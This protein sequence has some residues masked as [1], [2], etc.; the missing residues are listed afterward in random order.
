MLQLSISILALVT[1]LIAAFI[2][3]H[4]LGTK[5]SEYDHEPDV[6]PSRRSI[7][8]DI[9]A[10]VDLSRTSIPKHEKKK[11]RTYTLFLAIIVL[12][13]PFAIYGIYINQNAPNCTKYDRYLKRGFQGEII[14][15]SPLGRPPH[16]LGTLTI[17]YNGDT[18]NEIESVKYFQKLYDLS[19]LGDFILKKENEEVLFLRRNK[20]RFKLHPEKSQLD[21][22]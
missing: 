10:G 2:F 3:Y 8:H 6:L 17:L 7:L 22:D 1:L 12:F 15:K 9:V 21:C 19:E 18:L 14:G 5:L 11:V 4:L 13:I 20:T 16:I